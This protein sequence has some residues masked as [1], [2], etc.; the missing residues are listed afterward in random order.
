MAGEKKRE[1]KLKYVMRNMASKYDMTK[2][3]KTKRE[4]KEN[5]AGGRPQGERKLKSEQF[6]AFA[7]EGFER[8]EARKQQQRPRG[9]TRAVRLI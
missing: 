5:I 8:T 2:L 3:H 7:D 6:E 4:I 9:E 1:T